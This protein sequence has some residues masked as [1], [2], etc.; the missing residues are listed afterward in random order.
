MGVELYRKMSN[1]I[2]EFPNCPPLQEVSA[3]STLAVCTPSPAVHYQVFEMVSRCEWGRE[4]VLEAELY[5][6]L[7]NAALNHQEHELVSK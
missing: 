6:H 5:T 4:V 2:F 3:S 7:A 1:G